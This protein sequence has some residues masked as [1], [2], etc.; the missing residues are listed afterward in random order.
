MKKYKHLDKEQTSQL[1]KDLKNFGLKDEVSK[2][3]G[4]TQLGI[5]MSP[6]NERGPPP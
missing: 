1:F 3:F 6:T 2:V 5:G 4:N